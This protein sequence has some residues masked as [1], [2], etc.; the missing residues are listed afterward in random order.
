MFVVVFAVFFV[1]IFDMT[2]FVVGYQGQDPRGL[3]ACAQIHLNPLIHSNTH[4]HTHALTHTHAYT[5][6]QTYIKHN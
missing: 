2:L 5:H 1:Y 6:T 4:T 3:T